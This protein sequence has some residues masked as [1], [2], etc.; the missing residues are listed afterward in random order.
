MVWRTFVYRNYMVW[1]TVVHTIHDMLS[2]L[3]IWCGHI[4]WAHLS[5]PDVGSYLRVSYEYTLHCHLRVS[6]EYTLQFQIWHRGISAPFIWQ[7]AI[8]LGG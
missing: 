2:T 1:T 7:E 3:Y 6:Y 4:V 8:F 5:F